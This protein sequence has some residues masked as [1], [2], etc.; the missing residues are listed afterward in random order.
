ML[1]RVVCFI[2]DPTARGDDL[3]RRGLAEMRE[4]SYLMFYPFF[5]SELAGALGTVGRID[6]GL[7]E[8][9]GAMRFAEQTG[10]RWLVPE[11]FRTKG[12]L[13]ALRGSKDPAMAADWLLRSMSRARDQQALYWE[14]R[15]PRAATS[16]ARLL[17]D[18]GRFGEAL[19]YLRPGYNRFSDG[20]DTTDLMAAGALLDS[21]RQAQSADYMGSLTKS[22]LDPTR[23]VCWRRPE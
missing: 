4:A 10:C 22:R 19:A 8:I 1:S 16:L 21:L 12:E 2:L 13:L 7:A 3:L 6:D 9:D 15:A 17:R 14:L 5:R 23:D 18:Q 11:I 20:F